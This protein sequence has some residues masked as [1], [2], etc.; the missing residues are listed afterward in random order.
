MCSFYNS[1]NNRLLNLPA[2]I[3][4]YFQLRIQVVGLIEK[5]LRS[6]T[7]E[8]VVVEMMLLTTLVMT[9]V[10]VMRGS[11]TEFN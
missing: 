3:A 6:F 7:C 5:C 11:A 8:V 4:S 2:A 10:R 9:T 1:H